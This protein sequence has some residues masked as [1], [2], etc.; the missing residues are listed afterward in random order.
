MHDLLM[1]PNNRFTKQKLN[2]WFNTHRKL[3]SFFEPQVRGCFFVAIKALTG[4]GAN[5]FA[6][7]VFAQGR[8]T[9]VSNETPL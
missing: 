4:I 2:I 9:A 7:L 8:E 1:K 3:F 6:G 5:R